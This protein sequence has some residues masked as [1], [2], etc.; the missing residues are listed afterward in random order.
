MKR[1][2]PDWWLEQA[3]IALDHFERA[4]CDDDLGDAWW[5]LTEFCRWSRRSRRA[6]PTQTAQADYLMDKL[7]AAP[8][9][10]EQSYE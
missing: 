5:W 8:R 4:P 6:T 3:R 10:L 7:I 1:I 2:D 9:L